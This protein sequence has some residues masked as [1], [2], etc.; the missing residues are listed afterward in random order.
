MI[1]WTGMN[2][3]TGKHL[4]ESDHIKQ[5]VR[6]ILTTPIGSR[7][8]RREY[9]SE[10]IDLIDQ[11]HNEAT[12][13]RMIAATVHALTLW[14]PRIKITRINIDNPQ[15]DGSAAINLKWKRTDTGI[16][17]TGAIAIPGASA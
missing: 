3:A 13:L 12:R 9:G 14:E 11:P 8:M 6:D 1:T 5:S 7:I 15:F 17:E 10:L 2:A 4:S 16:T